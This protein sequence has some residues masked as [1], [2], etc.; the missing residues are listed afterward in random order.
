MSEQAR[1]PLGPPFT[2]PMPT[3]RQRIINDELVHE[4][5]Y[6]YD[7]EEAV[8]RRIFAAMDRLRRERNN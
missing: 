6:G 4:M 8:K 7:G 2:L 1:R 3:T 5:L